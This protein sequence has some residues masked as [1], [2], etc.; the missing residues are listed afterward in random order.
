[1]ARNLG[2][3]VPAG[4]LRDADG[5]PTTDPNVLYTEPRGALQPLGSPDLGH[6]GS[7]LGMAVEVMATLLAGERADDPERDNNLT[8]VAL[9]TDDDFVP[10]ADAY[11]DYVHAATPIDPSRPPLV[12]GEVEATHRRRATTVTVDGPT[13]QAIIERAQRTGVS[14][15]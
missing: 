6:K 15:P 11:I 14:R 12:P 5:V 10:R 2:E 9:A 1:M 8:L 4:L 7:A 3:P 13:W